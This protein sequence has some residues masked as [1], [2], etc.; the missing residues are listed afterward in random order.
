MTSDDSDEEPLST[1]AAY[2]RKHES[3]VEIIPVYTDTKRTPKKKKSTKKQCGV[4][5]ELARAESP[6]VLER[7]MDVWMYLKDLNPTGPYS[8][9]LC[10]EWFINK[11]KIVIHY[12]VDHRK[13]FCGICRYVTQHTKYVTSNITFKVN[14]KLKVCEPTTFITLE[15]ITCTIT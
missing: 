2:K 6:P 9:L 15:H 1:L 14:V 11:T 8:C 7:P 4:T 13:N 3:E 5:I 12:I 10:E